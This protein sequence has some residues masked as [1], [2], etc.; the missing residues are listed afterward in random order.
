MFSRGPS[1]FFKI[2]TRGRACS[3]IL[4]TNYDAPAENRDLKIWIR[5]ARARLSLEVKNGGAILN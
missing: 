3:I 1:S 2:I 4:K 5:G